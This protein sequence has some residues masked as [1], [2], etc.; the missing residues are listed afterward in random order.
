MTKQKNIIIDKGDKRFVVTSNLF[1]IEDESDESK[2]SGVK[3]IYRGN[4]KPV[5]GSVPKKF[6]NLP[7]GAYLHRGLSV[8]SLIGSSVFSKPR[9]K[10]RSRIKSSSSTKKV[11]VSGAAK[12]IQISERIV[13]WSKLME[14]FYQRDM[15][16][17]KSAISSDNESIDQLRKKYNDYLL[18]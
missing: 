5:E 14:R 6:E 2:M 17:T 13:T 15:W 16:E 11:S 10:N 7:M 18:K 12:T 4:Y 9:S 8:R 3:Y 1:Q